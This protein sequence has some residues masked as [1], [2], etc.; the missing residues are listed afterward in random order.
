M[1]VVYLNIA[2]DS[3]V[4]NNFTYFSTGLYLSNTLVIESI[5]FNNSIVAT[6]KSSLST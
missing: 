4:V 1:L 6:F 5:E 3:S 2:F